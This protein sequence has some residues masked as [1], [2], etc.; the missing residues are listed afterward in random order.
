MLFSL[1]RHVG[2]EDRKVEYRSVAQSAIH[3]FSPLI[4]KAGQDST[5]SCEIRLLVLRAIKQAAKY[6]PGAA[7]QHVQAF[8][9]VI[10]AGLHDFDLSVKK[11]SERAMK[12][13]VSLF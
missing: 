3:S 10:V 12:H 9:P 2:A 4:G 11:G 1:P 13:M 7:S 5:A 8:M 6:F